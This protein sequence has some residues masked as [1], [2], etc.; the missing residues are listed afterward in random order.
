MTTKLSGFTLIFI[1]TSFLFSGCFIDG[2]LEGSG[3]GT[4]INVDPDFSD[5]VFGTA[6][7]Y[8]SEIRVTL[9]FFK[10]K[11]VNAIVESI[12]GTETPGI[13]TEAIKKAPGLIVAMQ[14][15]D[16][17]SAVTA[18]KT[19]NGIKEAGEKALAKVP[20]PGVVPEVNMIAKTY[21][22]LATNA[23]GGS[24]YVLVT[25]NTS[26]ITGIT[27]EYSDE[28]AAGQAAIPILI[29][30]ILDAQ[31]SGVDGISGA[32][33]TSDA[34]KRAVSDALDEAGAPPFMMS[35]PKGLD[36]KYENSR[37][38]DV[39]VIGSGAAGLSAAIEAAYTFPPIS[40]ML[41]EKEDLIGGSAQL[42]HGV[43]YA[44]VDQT[45][46]TTMKDYLLFRAQDYADND[47][48]DVYV[49]Y[50]LQLVNGSWILPNLTYTFSSGATTDF[51]SGMASAL[52]ARMVPGGGAGLV[53]ILENKARENGVAIMTGI[54]A[55]ELVKNIDAPGQPVVRVLAKSKTASYIFNV[56][57]GVVVA[58]GGFDHDPVLLTRN[59]PALNEDNIFPISNSGNKGEG[60]TI[61]EAIG[62]KT[63]F[64]GGMI[65]WGIVDPTAMVDIPNAANIIE[66][67]NYDGS[68]SLLDTTSPHENIATDSTPLTPINGWY[69]P[70][71]PHN[72][73]G[74]G[75][76]DEN[77][78]MAIMFNRLI[79]A[80]NRRFY[81][82]SNTPFPKTGSY[83]QE[84]L[85]HLHVA[86][87]AESIYDL[88]NELLHFATL[89]PSNFE[90]VVS[91]MG[92]DSS[93]MYY[94][95]HVNPSSIGSM[96]G[97]KINPNAQVLGDGT[98]GTTN[99]VPIPGLFAAGEV[100]N[101]DFYYQQNPAMGSSLGIALTFGRIA[102]ENAAKAG[103]YALIV[104]DE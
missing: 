65:G 95:W 51:S 13:G 3:G 44:P 34:L 83:T 43:I 2:P 79:S 53:R 66:V 101:G 61:A 15:V 16:I 40:V 59:N 85:H 64:K 92:L 70:D 19:A 93:E 33:R 28:G 99:N 35:P 48:L 76:R 54:E 6:Y 97:L 73:S 10:G 81:Q 63:V 14:S 8:S 32:T 30:R 103:P 21:V 11:I 17:V 4:P 56:R 18:L 1:L 80:P 78:D 55:T 20:A 96:G 75:Q 87:S 12:S 26:A 46:G 91:G 9:E 104:D 68:V 27:V 37:T 77:K 84:D 86:Y 88:A 47:L 38:V 82:I 5:T 23:Y 42:S 90:S 74:A 62:A 52:R 50:S 72:P 36:N 69:D 49:N 58:T 67:N 39:L 102:G 98:K 22:K 89:D 24:F 7:G 25:V 29:N 57:R 45:D 60:I 71:N 41:I 100:A 94:A 31:T